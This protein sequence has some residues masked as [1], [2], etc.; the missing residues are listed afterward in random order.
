[1]SGNISRV[2]GLMMSA[3]ILLSL[4]LIYWVIWRG[5]E[6]LDLP[7]NARTVEFERRIQRGR[8]LD[9]TG[10]VLAETRL[11]DK[12]PVRVYHYPALAPVLGF[13]S[14]RYGV[15]GIEAA[16]NEELRGNISANAVEA[17]RHRLFHEP[18]VGYDVYLTLDLRLQQEADRLLGNRRGAVILL[19][20]DGSVLAMASHPSYDP[21]R[22]DE[23]FQQ[24]S[25]DPSAPLVNR[26]TQGLYPPGSTWKTETLAAALDA[27]ITRPDRIYN[28]GAETLVV[29]GFPIRCN[30]NPPGVNSFDL[31]HAF[32][33]SCNLTFARLALELG[34]LRYTDY[35]QRFRAHTDLPFEIPVAKSQIANTDLSNE[36]LLASTGFGQ[37]E[38]QVTPLAIA[39]IGATIANDGQMPRPHLLSE[40]KDKT[41]QRL[42]G[43]DTGILGT[44]IKPETAAEVRSIMEVAVTDGYASNAKVQG[45]RVGGKTGT[46]ETGRQTR[47]H[48]WFIGIAPIDA[49]RYIVVVMIENGGEGSTEAAPLAGRLLAQ[50]LR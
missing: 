39:M 17:L 30:N 40:I 12:G 4:S 29:R 25:S 6:L 9:R 34:A 24:L 1:M 8:I 41:G 43:P 35:A 15:G 38:L 3:F 33:Y 7:N 27:G 19:D 48:A 2:A 45:V 21:N 31:V 28:D 46:A 49:P 16:F 32:G 47:P 14:F 20:R 22:F 26:A 42:R 18:V 11:T 13:Y 5:P 44:P 10:Q 50:A 37:G 23:T 36:V